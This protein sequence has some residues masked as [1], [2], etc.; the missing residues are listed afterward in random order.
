MSVFKITPYSQLACIMVLGRPLAPVKRVYSPRG[1]IV[2]VCGGGIGTIIRVWVCSR[3]T[4]R[5]AGISPWANICKTQR[6]VRDRPR[7]RRIFGIPGRSKV[8]LVGAG[9]RWGEGRKALACLVARSWA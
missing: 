7:T 6:G 9:C 2:A 3:Y 5:D 8:R 4:L 1:K